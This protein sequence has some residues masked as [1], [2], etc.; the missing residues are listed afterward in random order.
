MLPVLAMS[1]HRDT[2]VGVRWPEQ[3]F[4]W[5][6]VDVGGYHRA[7]GRIDDRLVESLRDLGFNMDDDAEVSVAYMH[8]T[9]SNVQPGAS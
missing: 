3:E 8:A 7:V 2:A 5:S 4:Q 6:T 1:I 9:Q